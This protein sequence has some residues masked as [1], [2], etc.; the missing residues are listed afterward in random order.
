M[1][2]FQN[3][4]VLIEAFKEADK[5]LDEE[6]IIGLDEVEQQLKELG[7]E[8]SFVVMDIKCRICGHEQS[9]IVPEVADLDN[10][11]CINCEYMACQEKDEKINANRRQQIQRASGYSQ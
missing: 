6:L 2:I 1:I 11:E 9:I 5:Q 3:K 4:N 8:E 7:L 10:L